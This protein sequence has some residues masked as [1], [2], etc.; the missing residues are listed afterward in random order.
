MKK[1]KQVLKPGE[2]KERFNH[3]HSERATW[4]NHW[5]EL[6]DYILPNRNDINVVITPGSKR[7]TII[8]DNS[9]I[10][11]N[12]LLAGAM[13]GLLTNPST[14][15]FDLTTGDKE[16]DRLD[17]VRLWLQKQ[18]RKIHNVMNNSNFQTEVHQ[19][20][21]DLTCLGTSSMSIEE[22]DEMIVR[23]STKHIREVYVS[24]NNKGVID[25]V[26]RKFKWNIRA[27]VAEFGI[28]VLEMS[29]SL[30]TAWEKNTN[31]KFEI[32]NAV[33]P[34]DVADNNFKDSRRYISQYIIC[35]ENEKQLRLDY[36]REF[37][38]VVARW[39]KAAGEIYGRSPGMIALPD[40]K[41]LNKMTETTLKG[42]QKTVDPPL[43]LPDDGFIHPIDTRPSGL[44]YYRSGT[45]DRIEPIFNDARIDFGFQAMQE[46]RQRVRE[47]FFVD[48][49]QLGA[50]PQ[51]TATEVLQRTEEKMRLLGPMLGR[52]QAEFLRPMV[53]RVFEIM[54]RAGMIDQAP[55]ALEGRTLDVNYSSMV[56]KAQRVNDMQTIMQTMQA[57]NPF[58]AA[59]QSVL[60]NFNG[61]IAVRVIAEGYGFPQEILRT[62]EEIVSLREQR[63]QAQEQAM[64][65]QQEQ[66]QT[67]NAIK[68]V[69]A[70][71]TME[72]AQE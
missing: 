42:A 59:D 66:Q 18:T 39:T 19:Y 2:V 1:G 32:I 28:E 69:P 70:M 34:R 9:A 60:D 4:E 38:Y 47:A 46:R 54:S 6:A 50:G 16:L 61:D 65:A 57:V 7:N 37:P 48:Q 20:Y 63:A 21:L 71:A 15:W 13:H 67:E 35:A 41:T 36:Y 27:I 49:L 44:N 24:E 8:L 55:E 31:I 40:A 11:A 30:K 5:Q 56:A 58:V 68:G 53:S 25:E 23:F 3:L 43:Q 72:Q 17:A 10:Q 64:Q 22:D 45:N 52:Q 12:E 29:K 62:E 51:M 14:T 26:Y 33:Y